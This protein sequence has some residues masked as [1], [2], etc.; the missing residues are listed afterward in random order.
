MK[1]SFLIDYAKRCSYLGID[2]LAFVDKEIP[3]NNELRVHGFLEHRKE[4]KCL[5]CKIGYS[6]VQRNLHAFDCLTEDHV[7]REKK[8]S[9]DLFYKVIVLKK[10]AVQRL[11]R[12]NEYG[13]GFTIL[14]QLVVAIGGDG[15][16]RA[17][18]GNEIFCVPAFQTKYAAKHSYKMVYRSEILGLANPDAIR[19]FVRALVY[20]NFNN[21]Y[22][23]TL[24]GLKDNILELGGD[25][26]CL[27]FDELLG[28]FC[29][30]QSRFMYY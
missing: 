24:R 6:F 13:V 27:N 17:E 15:C 14:E 11:N 10:E 7:F 12:E 21:L 5:D 8:Y 25:V 4:M 2:C 26:S 29:D 22:F 9:K 20:H 30:L 3:I 16:F 1:S 23:N 28:E 18:K 19:Y